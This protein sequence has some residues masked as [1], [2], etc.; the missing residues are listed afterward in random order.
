M[1]DREIEIPETA[2]GKIISTGKLISTEAGTLLGRE[3]STLETPGR[4]IWTKLEISLDRRGPLK[5]LGNSAG[6]GL[7]E[8]R[9]QEA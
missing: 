6:K 8:S 1:G 4:P 2:Q 7:S 9:R 5:D 3:I